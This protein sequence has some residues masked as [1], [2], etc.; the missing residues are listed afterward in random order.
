[1]TQ[2]TFDLHHGHH[3][4]TALTTGFVQMFKAPAELVSTWHQRKRQ[5]QDLMAVTPRLLDDM[6]I[7]EVEREQE[8]RKPFWKA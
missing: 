6:G 1:M 4:Q 2:T 5:R 3:T 8:A 7:T